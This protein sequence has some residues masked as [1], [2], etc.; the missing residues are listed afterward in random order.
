M[1]VRTC[2]A[3]SPSRR[4]APDPFVQEQPYCRL[5]NHF[6]NYQEHN[7]GYTGR[8]NGI[9]KQPAVFLLFARPVMKTD[10]AT[11]G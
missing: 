8:D 1:K 9:A 7:R 6:S 10:K 2:A 3:H 5:G 4:T 11:P